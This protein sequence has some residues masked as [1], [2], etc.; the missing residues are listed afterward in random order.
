MSNMDCG[1]TQPKLL[2]TTVLGVG[3]DA[4]IALDGDGDRVIMVDERGEL[5]DGDQLIYILAVHAKTSRQLK[6]PVTL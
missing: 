2:Q 3:A 1:S 4:G 5:I 6:G